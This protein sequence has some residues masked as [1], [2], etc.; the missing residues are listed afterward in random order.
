MDPIKQAPIM[1]VTRPPTP[2]PTLSCPHNKGR[3]E[4][5]LRE[6]DGAYVDVKK[7]GAILEV[8]NVG[9]VMDWQKPGIIHG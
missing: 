8:E 9:T 5:E 4:V 3:D 2:Y 6:G 7:E 1:Q